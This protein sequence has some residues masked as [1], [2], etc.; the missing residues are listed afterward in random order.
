LNFLEFGIIHNLKEVE[1]QGLAFASKMTPTSNTIVV[2]KNKRAI[3]HITSPIEFS[4]FD[5]W[6]VEIGTWGFIQGAPSP[7]FII[8]I[9]LLQPKKVGI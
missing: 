6:R 3:S 8:F 7:T 1:Y 5:W 9:H 4:K 2:T